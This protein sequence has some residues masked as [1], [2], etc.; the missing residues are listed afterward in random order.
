MEFLP[1]KI[2]RLDCVV[3]FWFRISFWV[4]VCVSCTTIVLIKILFQNLSVLMAVEI[5]SIFVNGV[6][7]TSLLHLG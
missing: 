7:M 2:E 4:G 5:G 6:P 3:F 1:E